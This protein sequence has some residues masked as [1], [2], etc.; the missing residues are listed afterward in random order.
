[1]GT[2]GFARFRKASNGD[3]LL[4]W[5]FSL[6]CSRWTCCDVWLEEAKTTNEIDTPKQS[7]EQ[8]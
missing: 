6:F 5:L 1:L 4:Y 3:V 8:S 2:V 7:L